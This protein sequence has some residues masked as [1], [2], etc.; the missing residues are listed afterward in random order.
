MNK[1]AAIRQ[2]TN[3]SRMYRFGN[4]WQA[5]FYCAVNDWTQELWQ[6]SASYWTTRSSLT[7]IRTER[8]L[9]LLGMDEAIIAH[10]NS[11]TLT[12]DVRSRVNQAIEQDA[13]FIS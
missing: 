7:E 8:A 11:L 2:A 9:E 4:G 3:E 1:T 12:G 6:G 10:I 5:T 13:E